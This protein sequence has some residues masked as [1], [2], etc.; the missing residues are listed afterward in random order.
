MND[1]EEMADMSFDYIDASL[2]NWELRLPP[3]KRN[4][5]DTTGFVDEMLFQAHIIS[6]A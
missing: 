5:M 3:S 2:T 4:P 6:A 1:T